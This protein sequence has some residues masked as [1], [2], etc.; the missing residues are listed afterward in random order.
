MPSRAFKALKGLQR[1]WSLRRR[2]SACK[3]LKGLKGPS[4][5]LKGPYKSLKGHYKGLKG[6][7]V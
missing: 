4:K 5:S 3:S 7:Y 1:P 6:R 2:L